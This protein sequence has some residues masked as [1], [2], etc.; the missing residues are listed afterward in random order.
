M[1]LMLMMAVTENP[2]PMRLSLNLDPLDNKANV[3]TL[4]PFNGTS[5]VS[6]LE[7]QDINDLVFLRYCPAATSDIGCH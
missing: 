7:F 3:G 1:K 6:L 2:P 4:M 5:V